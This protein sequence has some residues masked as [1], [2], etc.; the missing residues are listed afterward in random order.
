MTLSDTRMGSGTRRRY[1]GTEHPTQRADYPQLICF[2]NS[3]VATCPCESK[4]KFG[5]GRKA[6]V[7][8]RPDS[9][10]GTGTK[11]NSTKIE[12]KSKFIE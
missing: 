6:S 4:E 3:V 8:G 2:S 5:L 9:G 10:A 7:A 12:V 1:D 11:R